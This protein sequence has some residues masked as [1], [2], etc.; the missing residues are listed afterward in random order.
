MSVEVGPLSGFR[1]LLVEDEPLVLMSLQDLIE[2]LGCIV[3]G[4]ATNLSEALAAISS[5]PAF[6]A[7]ILDV[8]VGRERIWPAADQL[9][10]S[11]IPFAFLSGYTKSTI[12]P[13]FLSMPII[14]KPFSDAAV[15]SAVVELC[16]AAGRTDVTAP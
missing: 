1:L 9:V 5:G 12:E 6:D 2:S 8:Q 14:A 7:A 13:R 11:S 15:K 3:V 4:T 16:V 10:S